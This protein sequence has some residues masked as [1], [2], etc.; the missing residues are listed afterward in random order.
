[1]CMAEKISHVF[2]VEIK[3]K[4]LLS[5]KELLRT[6]NFVSLED[7]SI[8]PIVALLILPDQR[9]Y[10]L[11]DIIIDIGAHRNVLDIRYNDLGL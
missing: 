4:K 3:F 5:V 11:P 1:M 8:L 9:Q 7:S 10:I 6:V 2:T